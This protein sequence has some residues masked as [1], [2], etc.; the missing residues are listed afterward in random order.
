[1]KSGQIDEKNKNVGPNLD[2]GNNNNFKVKSIKDNTV[3]TKK[4]ENKLLSIYYLI[5]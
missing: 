5:S 1:M 2:F 4:T 3:Y